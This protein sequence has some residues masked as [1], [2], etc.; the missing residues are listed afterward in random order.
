MNRRQAILGMG[1]AVS[2]M[3]AA[4]GTGA[5]TAGELSDRQATVTVTNDDQSLIALDPNDDLRGV[6]LENGELTVDLSDP[7]VNKN[8]IYQF[9]YFAEGENHSEE[10]P[11]LEEKESELGSNVFPVTMETPA[12]GS[13]FDSAFVVRNQSSSPKSVMLDFSVATDG[14]GSSEPGGTTF[15]YQ[16]H[17]KGET[18]TLVYPDD[19]N[20]TLSVAELGVGE[21][22]GVSFIVDA[23]EGDVGDQFN[24][25]FTV[26]AGTPQ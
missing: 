17:Y 6:K 8:S 1:A 21:A 19:E 7:G 3:S 23:T 2:G 10:Y 9:G 18:D 16:T 12:S 5:F 25:S 20:L 13:D 4:I 15:I 11:D 26:S 22:F 14:D 24:A